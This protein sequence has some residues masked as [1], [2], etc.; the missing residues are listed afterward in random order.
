MKGHGR[1]SFGATSRAPH[2]GIWV[3]GLIGR[4]GLYL[5]AILTGVAFSAT[6]VIALKAARG[7]V[8]VAA[9]QQDVAAGVPP[10]AVIAA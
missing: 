4:P 5:L 1:S 2:G 3:V 6:A 8:P 7:T 10:S 9:E